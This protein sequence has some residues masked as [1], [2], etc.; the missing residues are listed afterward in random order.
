MTTDIIL[1][2]LGESIETAVIAAWHKQAGDEV[3]RGD[4]L[5]DVE[6]DKA[7]MPL[8]CPQNGVLL[9]VLVEEG[10]EVR[11]GQRLA[12]V[13]RVGE[14]WSPEREDTDAQVEGTPNL[15][16]VDRTGAT[17]RSPTASQ[18]S[19][20]VRVTPLAR[21]RAKELGI[22]LDQVQPAQGDK[23][24]QDDVERH[25]AQQASVSNSIPSHRVELSNL[26]QRVGMRMLESTQNVPQYSVSVTADV[27]KL[28]AFREVLAAKDRKVSITALLIYL[29]THALR[30]HPLLNAQYDGDGVIVYDT[31]N[32]SLAVATP[33]GLRV[34]VIHQVEQ[35]A[36]MEISERTAALADNARHNRLSMADVTGGTFTVSNLGLFGVSQFVPI[37]NPPQ[38]AILGIGEPQVLYVPG[39]DGQPHP[40]QLMTLTVSADH[41][42]MDG[43]EVA[44][45]LATLKAAIE[46]CEIDRIT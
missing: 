24:S 34:P 19:R 22:A 29:V 8:E 45:F 4:E 42:V 20:Q 33:D 12:V 3:R 43:A 31:C 5:A 1:P 23:I 16:A 41:R 11:V 6:T 40:A 10:M 36:L 44:V 27:G 15:A 2:H 14:E 25:A 26:R 35:M 30:Q 13:G 46:K 17:P 7:T 18:R 21:R 38:A 32:I 28:L 39:A 37:V 9:A